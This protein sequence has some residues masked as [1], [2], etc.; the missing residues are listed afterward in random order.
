M[1]RDFKLY[2]DDI[3]E[4]AEKVSRY[5]RGLSFDQ[6][7]GD[8]KTFDAVV[9]NLE[10]IG[11][12]TKHIPPDVRERYPEVEWRRIAGLRDVVIHEYFGID[13]LI[14]WD[15]IQNHVPRLLDQIRAILAEDS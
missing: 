15:I 11:E 9:R 2:L 10:I 5:T 6:F 12:A 4:S 7:V 14:L 3:R 13:D 8:E 1:S